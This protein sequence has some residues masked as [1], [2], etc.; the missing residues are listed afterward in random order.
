MA[1]WLLLG[2]LGLAAASA[3][4]LGLTI[5]DEQ[6][7]AELGLS[8]INATLLLQEE[9]VECPQPRCP[10]RL[11]CLQRR[12]RRD[13]R[14]R[15]RLGHVAHVSLGGLGGLGSRRSQRSVGHAS[16]LRLGPRR[17]PVKLPL[18]DL[19]LQLD[20]CATKTNAN[21]EVIEQ[22]TSRR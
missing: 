19:T 2:Y 6:E 3:V 22:R 8:R 18:R 21:T 5:E 14:R 15:V 11:Q 9:V 10:A 16:L 17:R 13:R 20:R 12:R 7:F 4:D 1:R